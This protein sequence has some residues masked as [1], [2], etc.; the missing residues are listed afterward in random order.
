MPNVFKYEL[1]IDVPDYV[2]LKLE[3][4]TVTV[5]GKLG[6]ITKDFSHMKNIEISYENKKLKILSFFPK[7]KTIASM[8]T[9][10]SLVVNAIEGV[11]KG[12]EYRM[13][14]AYS[15]FPITLET[16]GRE[17]YIKNFLGERSPRIT[18]KV[19]DD[20]EIKASKEDVIVKGIDKEEVSQ[21]AANIQ[22]RCRIRRKDSRS[23]MDGIYV[24]Q[25]LLGD[26]VIWTLKY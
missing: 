5:K 1:E 22:K 14:I 26:K 8:G 20:V 18:Y 7:K 4:M 2:D 23:F 16:K 15:H 6:T 10:K 11:D 19:S 25:K 13:K 3:G 21:T 17:I 9:L 24:W 12:Y